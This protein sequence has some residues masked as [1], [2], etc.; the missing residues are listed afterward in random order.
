MKRILFALVLLPLQLALAN[1]F[2]EMILWRYSSPIVPAGQYGSSPEQICRIGPNV[3]L[4]YSNPYNLRSL[5]WNFAAVNY[6]L[7]RWGVSG[8]F[9]SYSLNGL[10]GDYKTSMAFAYEPVE[11][12]GVS[13]SID[14]SRLKF[15][16][17][18]SYN[19]IDLNI[20]L[21]YTRKKFTG[22]LAINRINIKKPYDYPERVEPLILGAVD[23]G[24]G[25]IFNAGYKRTF[26]GESRWLFR[27]NIEIVRGA[28]LNLGYMNNPNLLQWGL[29]L[30]WKS[31][32]LSFGYHAVSR[33][34][35]TMV[36]GLSWG[37]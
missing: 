2:D 6:G 16:E 35:D 12:L 32:N 5:S 22:L 37:I 7:G 31:L 17:D 28:N 33:L 25:M 23:L 8:A 30:S 34:N 26:T 15:G 20:A 27:Q 13:S 24:Q 29:D 10:Y 11:N 21:S 36:M 1:G 9:R 3:L 18:A 14:Y 4:L 19:R